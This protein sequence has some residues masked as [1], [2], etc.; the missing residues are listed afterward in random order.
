MSDLLVTDVVTGGREGAA[1]SPP[2]GK[3]QGPFAG[4][5]GKRGRESFLIVEEPAWPLSEDGAEL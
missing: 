5:A 3:A 1:T 4:S 2:K